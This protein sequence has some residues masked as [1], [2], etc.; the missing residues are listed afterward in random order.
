MRKIILLISLMFLFVG[1]STMKVDIDYDSAYNFDDKSSYA[2]VHKNREG[3]NSLTNDRIVNAIKSSL[4]KKKY[5][6]VSQ[7][8]ADLIFVF[9][10]NVRNRSDIRSDY[11]RIGYGGY[12]YGYGGG[13]GG[14]GRAYGTRVISV[15][16]TYS[17]IE[18]KL[19][20]DAMN[21]KT[22]KIVWRG[23]ISDELSR[24]ESTPQEKTAFINKVV[25]KLMKKFPKN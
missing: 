16:S 17:W 7:D 4:N 6:E 21:P 20:I 19:I 10:A 22:K 11:E 25:D 2:V 8:N 23:V 15:P 24:N 5:R 14:Y 9:H 13:F 1:C 18:G 3:E 12:G